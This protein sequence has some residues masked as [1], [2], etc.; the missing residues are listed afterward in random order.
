MNSEFHKVDLNRIRYSIVWEDYQSLYDGLCINNID[1]VLIITSAGCNALNALLK[2]PKQIHAVDINP[3]QN[4]LLEF[5]LKIY[6]HS[7]YETLSVLLGLN[8]ERSCIDAFKKVSKY[9]NK[10]DEE[11]WCTFF[12]QNTE[13]LLCSGQLERYIHGFYKNLENK[14]QEIVDTIFNSETIDEQVEKFNY[15]IENTGF[16]QKFK[17]HFDD[18]HLSKGRDPRLF[19]YAKENGG[20]AFYKRLVKHVHNSILKNNFYMYF[21]FYGLNGMN[22]NI[23][24]P[25]YKKENFQYIKEHTES[26]KMHTLDVIDFIEQSDVYTISKASLSNIFEYTST[27]EFENAI[28]IIQQK[29]KLHTIIFWNLLH[30]QG[31]TEYALKYVNKELSE[32]ISNKES[33]FYFKNLRVLNF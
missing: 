33:C 26:I 4:K 13:G 21:F 15:L 3:Y 32:K 25:C 5:K 7:N 27:D 2:K 31:N 10:E 29:S 16:E 8:R 22:E 12:T 9:F 30:E 18:E 17:L 6:K 14:E 23:L 20:S 28:K 19:K 24:P 11:A 1:E